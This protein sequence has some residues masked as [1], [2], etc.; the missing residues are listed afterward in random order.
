MRMV[1]DEVAR[2]SSDH[3]QLSIAAYSRPPKPE[4]EGLEPL[5]SHPDVPSSL[6]AYFIPGKS[7]ST[8]S[9]RLDNPV[10]S[11]SFVQGEIVELPSRSEQCPDPCRASSAYRFSARSRRSECAAQHDL[12]PLRTRSAAARGGAILSLPQRGERRGR[13]H[14]ASAVGSAMRRAD[15][16]SRRGERSVR[17]SLCT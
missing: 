14:I 4:L 8:L 7:D 13:G 10:G 16:W 6:R 9:M 17:R 3:Y 1:P 2:R 12:N 15:A 11:E 5:L